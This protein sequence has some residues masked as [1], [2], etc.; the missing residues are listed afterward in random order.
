MRNLS[1]TPDEHTW[2]TELVHSARRFAANEPEDALSTSVLAKLVEA[3]LPANG[4]ELT[5]PKPNQ[6]IGC[7]QSVAEEGAFGE[8]IWTDHLR[9]CTDCQQAMAD[10]LADDLDSQE[11]ELVRAV[12]DLTSSDTAPVPIPAD[13]TA[14]QVAAELGLFQPDLYAVVSIPRG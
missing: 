7:F 12:L 2:L 9:G 11:P 10:A 4:N 6:Q 1:L 13:K 5:L 8:E 14:E 3:G